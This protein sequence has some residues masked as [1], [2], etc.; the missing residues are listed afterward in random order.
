MNTRREGSRSADVI[1]RKF[2]LL[3]VVARA[4][5]NKDAHSVWTCQCECGG[6]AAPTTNSL[7]RGTS[8]SCG[9]LRAIRTRE[10]VATHGCSVGDVPVEYRRWLAMKARCRN[11]DS[12]QGRWH[13]ARGIKVCARWENDFAAFW[14]DMGPIPSPDHT[15]ERKDNDLGYEPSNCRW[16]TKEEQNH[17]K[18]SNRFVEVA[19]ERLTLTQAC[20]KHGIK[21]QLVR[22]RLNN[23]W[24]VERAFNLP[25]DQTSPSQTRLPASQ[26]DG[27][28]PPC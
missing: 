21:Y 27:R 15:L 7:N 8:T 5:T 18:R 24:S 28:S 4:G 20:Q 19:G 12:A 22:W 26:P 13:A 2:G 1:G 23:G 3:T 10:A 9:C 11:P 14:R 17:N 16:A 6:A 25:P